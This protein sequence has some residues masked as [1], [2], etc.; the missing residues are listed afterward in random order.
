MGLEDKVRKKA[1]QKDL[2]KP[3]IFSGKL[4]SALT[5]TGLGATVIAIPPTDF[6]NFNDFSAI[7]NYGGVSLIG[8]GI[9]Y[10]SYSVKNYFSEKRK[11]FQLLKKEEKENN[12]YK[13]NIES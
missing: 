4:L 6:S 5:M 12:L 11:Y 3:K 8:L 9:L 2:Y 13:N 1:N 10:S 7:I